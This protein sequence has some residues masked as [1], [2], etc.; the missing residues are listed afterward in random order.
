MEPP[1]LAVESLL[2]P[3]A[4]GVFCPVRTASQHE[5]MTVRTIRN[6]SL[7]LAGCLW[8]PLACSPGEYAKQADRVAYSVV[9]YGQREA[10][11]DASGF[12]VDYQP[13]GAALDQGNAIQVGQKVI[14][15]GLSAQPVTL[16]LQECIQVALQNSRN[17]Q[18]R[19]ERLYLAALAL[20]SSRR[21]WNWTLVEGS[22]DG[23]IRD[24]RVEH[25]GESSEFTTDDSV[26]LTRR[27][28]QGGVMVLAAGLNL[29][30]DLIGGSETL[31]GSTLEANFTQ[32]LLR[33]AWRDLAYEQQ[34]RRE[35]DFLFRV[36]EYDRFTQTFVADIVTQYYGVL[37]LLDQLENERANISRLE[38]TFELVKVQVQGGAVSPI[39]ADQSEQNLL[40]ARIR[41]ERLAQRYRDDL[42]SF[43]I[44][45]GLPVRSRLE[46]EYPAAL[47]RLK[48][49]A[50]QSGELPPL[51]FDE[52]QAI[53]AAMTSRPEVMRSRAALRDANRDV[54]IA[55]DAF[56]PQ[57]DLELGLDVPST[58]PSHVHRMRFHELTRTGRLRFRYPIDQTENRDAYRAS[59]LSLQQARRQL[60]ELLDEVY[61]DVRQTYRELLRSSRTYEIRLRSVQIAERRRRLAVLQQKQGQ[62]SARDVLEAEEALRESQ[63]GLTNAI[64]SYTTTRLRFLAS[65]G[66]IGADEQGNIY[67]RTNPTRFDRL[68]WRYRYLQGMAEEDDDNDI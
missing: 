36:F 62:A 66:M 24:R 3:G 17:Y 15:V 55:A 18:D 16:T 52:A 35:R 50:K 45:L 33:G 20:G 10:L 46:L 13:Y 9:R 26:S 19:K 21:D 61:L 54:Q 22:V 7:L 43:K 30:T 63:N 41:L 42:D 53:E 27:F 32:P 29:A 25:A 57:L 40:D 5:K 68:A 58:D 64:V 48:E 6:L 38:Q 31:A 2:S 59:L 67:E 60:D 1:R 34:Y 14:P 56:L 12:H 37:E 4:S 8:A 39:Q 28:A 51:P 47:T 44:Q 23:D 49:S 65:L 11:G